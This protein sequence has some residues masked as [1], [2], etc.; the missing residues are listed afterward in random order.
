MK[1]NRDQF[2]VEL[3]KRNIGTGI[4]YTAVHLH[5]YYKRKYLYK[6]TDFPNS[7]WISKRTLSLPL[8]PKISS[9]DIADVI[10]AVLDIIKKYRT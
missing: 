8:S 5:K 6:E 4:H 9:K 1:I 2:M 3:K 10:T 7:E